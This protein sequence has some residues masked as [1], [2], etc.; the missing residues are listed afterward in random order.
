MKSLEKQVLWVGVGPGDPELITVKGLKAI[1]QADVLL[2][3]DWI[4]PEFLVHASSSCDKCVIN[5]STRDHRLNHSQTTE[6]IVQYAYRYKRVVRLAGGDPNVFGRAYAEA[7]FVK[8]RGVHVQIIPGISSATAGPCAAGIPLTLRGINESFCVIDG[9]QR[10]GKL[11]D[12]L[13]F[14]ANS[15]AS[16]IIMMGL[17]SL[18]E[19]A[20]LMSLYRSPSEPVAVVEHATTKHQRVIRGVA[21]DIC[22]R[23]EEAGI[24]APAIIIV[25]QVAGE[26]VLRKCNLMVSGTLISEHS[27]ALPSKS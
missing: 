11:S 27:L 10:S 9:I 6:L 19:I 14:A 5:T 1:Q 12:D 17:P 20:S 13:Y 24:E 26:E 7:A 15:T 22:H 4:D 25:G 23:V 3:D 18:K 21:A 2:Y 8:S 16:I